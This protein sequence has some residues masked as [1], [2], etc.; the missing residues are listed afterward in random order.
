MTQN[1]RMTPVGHQPKPTERSSNPQSYSEKSRNFEILR[2]EKNIF[3]FE[4]QH[5][6]SKEDPFY[7]AFIEQNAT[8]ANTGTALGFD[9][10]Q[11]GYDIAQEKEVKS[12]QLDVKVDYWNILNKILNLFQ[13]LILTFFHLLHKLN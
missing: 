10:N 1:S 12:N 11:N 5:L 2:I 4:G 8:Y 9:P 3:A 7:N 13:I 6:L